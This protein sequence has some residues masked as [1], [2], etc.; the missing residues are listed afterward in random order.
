MYYKVVTHDLQSTG[1]DIDER[2]KVQ[3]IKGEW[4]GGRIPQAPL[5]VFNNLTRARA[6]LER[7]CTTGRIFECE[8]KK[9]KRKWGAMSEPYIDKI[10]SNIRRKK[11]YTDIV[12]GMMTPS[13]TIYADEVK[14]T[15][16]LLDF[17]ERVFYKVVDKY[18]RSAVSIAKSAGIDVQYRVGYETYPKV[19][20]APLMVFKTLHEAQ[21]FRGTNSTIF[22][23]LKIF[24]CKIKKSN[25]SWKP[26]DEGT[27]DEVL[28]LIK[29]N[30]DFTTTLYDGAHIRCNPIF[31]DSVT[32][33]KEVPV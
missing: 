4:I 16:E 8:I 22:N 21:V 3:Y 30:K 28:R 10:L 20:E 24:T 29:Q 26:T 15:N 17:P 6:Y 27:L 18:L 2:L 31:A 11:K 25:R 32:L 1:L 14:L 5:F 7:C 19:K 23:K 13:H 9:S 12:Y 33:L